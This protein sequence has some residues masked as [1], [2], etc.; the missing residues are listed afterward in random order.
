MG[1]E[2]L[3]LSVVELLDVVVDVEVIVVR[4]MVL[5]CCGSSVVGGD[6]SVLVR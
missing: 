3:P 5:F 1:A 6:V 2:D 4:A